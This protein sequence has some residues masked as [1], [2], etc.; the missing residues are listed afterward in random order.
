MTPFRFTPLLKTPL[1]GGR[2]IV[3]VKGITNHK[4]VGESWEISGLKGE[5]TIVSEG[6]DT[7]KNLVQLIE[8]YGAALMGAENLQRYGKDFPLLIKFISAAQPLSIQVHPDDEMAQKLEN[9]PYGKSEMWYVVDTHEGASLYNG[10]KET[11]SLEAFDQATAEHRLSEHLA[12]Y[13]TQAGD[14]FFIPA[15]QIHSIGSG[16][17]IIEIQQSCNLVYRVCDFNRVD[18]NG[19]KRELHLEQARKALNFETRSDYQ[20]HYTPREN[21]RILL[22]Q[23]AEF[24][25]GLYHLTQPLRADYSHL[26]S[27]VI[28][29]A[30]A[31]TA[32]LTDGHGH[33]L[34]LRAGESILF[35]AENAFVDIE[36]IG[37]TRFS[38]IETYVDPSERPKP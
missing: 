19:Q 38:C 7:G 13:N 23:H 1:W 27:F 14:C 2:D 8:Q 12:R 25:T 20:S 11:L 4:T 33:S 34:T 5:E 26:D 9:A 29:I 22:E 37:E 17:F 32:R 18:A 16:N 35:P 28:F 30:F 36:P 15:G 24:T 21:E 31:G 3:A 10:F 6:P